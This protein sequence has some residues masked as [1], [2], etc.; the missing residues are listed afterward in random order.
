MAPKRCTIPNLPQ[1][2]FAMPCGPS[3]G[4]GRAMVVATAPPWIVLRR[5]TRKST[6]EKQ[7][8][9][10]HQTCT[11]GTTISVACRPP[12]P[13][14]PGRGRD[15]CRCR[16]PL[17]PGNQSVIFWACARARSQ[18]RTHGIEISIHKHNHNHKRRISRLIS[19]CLQKLV[20]IYT[21]ALTRNLNLPPVITATTILAVKLLPSVNTAKVSFSLK[22]WRR[23][24]RRAPPPPSRAPSRRPS[25]RAASRAPWRSTRRRA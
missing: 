18:G 6:E 10:R 17:A 20:Q 5:N 11:A 2:M 21:L 15:T 12:C 25:W 22:E 3:R 4:R 13:P 9:S 23:W 19:R 8:R 7:E 14:D 24:S 16:R 1:R